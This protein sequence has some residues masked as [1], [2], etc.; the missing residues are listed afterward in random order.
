MG[1]PRPKSS[2]LGQELFYYTYYRDVVRD[3]G[4]TYHGRKRYHPRGEECQYI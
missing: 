2:R 1:K 3:I 4:I